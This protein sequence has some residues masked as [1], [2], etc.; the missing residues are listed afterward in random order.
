MGEAK[1]DPAHVRVLGV[2]GL[3]TREA[4]ALLAI[5]TYRTTNP[6]EVAGL[7]GVPKSKIYSTMADLSRKSYLS[8]DGKNYRLNPRTLSMLRDSV[9]RV[10]TSYSQFLSRMAELNPEVS[11]KLADEV[12]N[13]FRELNFDV[14]SKG[15][16]KVSP[17]LVARLEGSRSGHLFF[18]SITSISAISS[19][20][21]HRVTVLILPTIPN[22][23]RVDTYDV[24]SYLSVFTDRMM[25]FD[26]DR[27]FILGDEIFREAI[28]RFGQRT[29]QDAQFLPLLSD[30]V[31]TIRNTLLQFDRQWQQK[32]E[33]VMRLQADAETPYREITRLS[34]FL[35]ELRGLIKDETGREK[36][37][38]QALNEILDRMNADLHAVS[39]IHMDLRYN[40]K[41]LLNNL[42]ERRRLP[43][44]E[45]VIRAQ[46]SIQN[47]TNEVERLSKEASTLQEELVYL[48]REDSRYKEKGY[49]VN[50]FVFTIPVEGH[51]DLVNQE[52][53]VSRISEFIRQL[54]SGEYTRNTLFLVDEPGTGKTH[55]M[56]YFLSRVNNKEMGAALGLYLRCLPGTDLISLFNQLPLAVESQVQDEELK[57]LL[58]S[59]VVQAVA[60]PMTVNDFVDLLRRMSQIAYE[61]G[62][63]AFLLFIDEFENVLSTSH[64]STTAFLQLRSLM[65]TAHVGYVVAMRRE[66]W[67]SS[68]KQD[69]RVFS[70]LRPY[71][72]LELER[73]TA[74]TVRE[75][76]RKRLEMFGGNKSTVAFS[77]GAVQEITLAAKGIPREVIRYARD[78]F[79]LGLVGGNDQIGIDTIRQL[80]NAPVLAAS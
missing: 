46:S 28:E 26:Y 77:D 25:G 21:G 43:T 52:E 29:E 24:F 5:I 58:K 14:V 18:E 9:E 63:R 6:S 69:E 16:T 51:L 62:R 1:I 47:L 33:M 30:F 38:H 55:L 11:L 50:P 3:T 48:Y 44:D 13:M 27:L 49:L 65:E 19:T 20:S 66:F 42:R 17:D 78:A 64:E 7:S 35:N 70:T 59:V 37:L 41:R 76:L 36:W 61:R 74:R 57:T 67:E 15:P 39:E 32:R 40:A 71:V 73:F 60:T 68:A 31:P 45:N 10:V 75:L 2:V 54:T 72:R 23:R 80:T 8:S 12:E 34:N 53:S 4:R 56:K 22:M 79:R